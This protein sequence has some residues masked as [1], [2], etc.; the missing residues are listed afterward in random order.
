MKKNEQELKN[1]IRLRLSEALRSL[2]GNSG[3]HAFRFHVEKRL[4]MDMHEAFYEDPHRFY[5]AVEDVFGRGADALIRLIFDWLVQ[6]GY[7]EAENLT[8]NDFIKFLKEGGEK[9]RIMIISS[10]KGKPKG[11]DTN[12]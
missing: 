4:G 2:L 12:P 10:F 6:N 8:A 1:V 5:E 11:G 9:A 7:L 3:L